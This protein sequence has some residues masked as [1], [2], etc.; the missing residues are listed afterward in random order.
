MGRSF[1]RTIREGSQKSAH[2]CRVFPMQVTFQTQ[3]FFIWSDTQSTYIYRV[4]SSVWRLLNYWPPTPSPPS[5]C[6][7]PTHQRRGGRVHTLVGWWGGQYFGR[8]QTLDGPLTVYSLYGLL[9]SLLLY[10]MSWQ[11]WSLAQ[12]ALV[13]HVSPLGGRHAA[14]NS[15]L[16]SVHWHRNLPSFLNNFPWFESLSKELTRG[17]PRVSSALSFIGGVHIGARALHVLNW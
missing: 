17:P 2:D 15:W 16:P 14:P 5:E 3:I 12:S 6:V 10:L 9:F 13:W 1:I 11:T 8:R 4:Q 7:L